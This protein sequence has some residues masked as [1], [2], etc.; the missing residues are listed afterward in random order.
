[1]KK[2]HKAPKRIG[3]R[4]ICGIRVPIYL[5]TVDE[6]SELSGCDGWW[7]AVRNII[8]IRDGQAESQQR[9]AVV[10]EQAHAFLYL[11]GLSVTLK[12]L[13]GPK[14]AEHWDGDDG[15][16]EALVRQATPHLVALLGGGKWR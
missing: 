3:L 5:A 13:L 4:T 1:M 14:R 15:I 2:P 10:H 11:S 16:E 8:W 9:D 7:D 12:M 6:V